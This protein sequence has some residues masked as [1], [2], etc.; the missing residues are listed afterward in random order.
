MFIEPRKYKNMASTYLM[1]FQENNVG[2]QD[3]TLNMTSFKWYKWCSS[4]GRR[5]E[6]SRKGDRTIHSCSF[7]SSNPS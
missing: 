3:G 7:T 1:S 6:E 4:H 2:F 5:M